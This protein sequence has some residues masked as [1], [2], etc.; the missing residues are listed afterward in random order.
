MP[1]AAGDKLGPYEI[2]APLG[3]GGMGEVYRARD[4]RLGRDVAIKVLPEHLSAHPEV[5]ARFEREAKTVSALQHPHVCTLFDVGHE[6]AIAYLVMELIEGETLAQRLSRGALP[7]SEVLKLGAQVAD[8]LD[9]AHRA[10]VV[11][12]DLKPG[13][14][15]LTRGG[16]KLMDFGLAR[17]TGLAAAGTGSTS[18]SMTHSPTVAAPLTTEG[19]IVGT[20][21]YM[22]P[23][24][25]EGAE[26]DE[27]ADLWA[28]GCVLHEMSTGRPAFA[29]RSQASLISAI[30]TSEPPPVSSLAPLAPAGFDRLVRTCLT[31]DREERA[32]SAHDV[33]LQLLGLQEASTASGMAAAPA[34]GHARRPYRTSMAWI[35]AAVASVVAI[36][37]AVTLVTRGGGGANEPMQLEVPTIARARLALYPSSLVVSPDGRTVAFVSRDSSKLAAL[38]V[39]RLDSNVPRKLFELEDWHGGVAILAWSPDGTKLVAGGNSTRLWIVPVEGSEPTPLLEARNTRGGSWGTKGTIVFARG[40]QSGLF[41]IAPGG[42]TPVQVTWPD[43]SRHES[44]HRFPCF[45]PDG[46]HFLFTVMPPDPEGYEIRVGSTRSRETRAVLRAQSSVTYAAPGWLLFR[47]DDKIV[48]QRFDPRACKVSGD[49]VVLADSPLRTD[50]DAEPVASASRNG[51]LLLLERTAPLAQ[52]AWIGRDGRVGPPLPMA[53]GAWETPEISPDGRFAAIPRDNDLWRIDLAS[54]TPLRLTSGPGYHN[55]PAWSPDGTKLVFSNGGVGREQL[56]VVNSDGSGTPTPLASGDDLFRSASSWSADGIFVSALNSSSALDIKRVPYPQGGSRT[57]IAT[58]FGEY[59]AQLSPDGRWLA[60]LSNEAGSG[61]L[62]VQSYPEPGHKLRVTTDGANKCWWVKGGSELV[63]TQ[64]TQ[65]RISGVRLVRRG[66]DLEVGER[67]F[68]FTAPDEILSA[69]PSPD[70]SRWLAV[71]A[72]PGGETRTARLFLNWTALAK[73]E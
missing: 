26:A 24:Q 40:P 30:M 46:E 7:P 66:D 27:R 15:M 53:A 59:G 12:R 55:F 61:D 65:Q 14:V 19:T 51:R 67:T 16:A 11:H 49:P 58:P 63:F 9:R 35:V 71:L 62:Y 18:L 41:T 72:Q 42:G 69:A 44:G 43:S 57:V 21:Q 68:Q 20:F 50:L 54:A 2:V 17:A 73:H 8:A 64:P 37:L 56:V 29:G 70:G 60:Y 36:A 47:R 34:T 45:L 48:A 4:T 3:A 5:R 31:K 10:G 28:L 33:K 52:L 22:A 38:W 1:L 25:L 6:G 23:E 13:N 32:R 39:R